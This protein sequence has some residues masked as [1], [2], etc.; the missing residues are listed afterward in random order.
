M[1][2]YVTG[3]EYLT[4]VRIHADRPG[5][6]LEIEWADGHRTEYDTV[7]LRWLCPCAY[8][9]G[10]RGGRPPP[11]LLHV[12]APARG[13]PLPRGHGASRLQAAHRPP[14]NGTA[15]GGADV[16]LEPAHRVDR[17]RA[18]PD[19]RNQHV[20]EGERPDDEA[21]EQDEVGRHLGPTF[22]CSARELPARD[23]EGLVAAHS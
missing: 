9:R 1:S 8:C 7:T 13:L 6:R 14:L 17:A 18:R 3:G 15:P 2:S 4:P 10:R 12:R 19:A 5:G 21:D 23:V 20:E 22:R 11:R 16:D